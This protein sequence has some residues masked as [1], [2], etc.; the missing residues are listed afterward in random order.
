ME[1]NRLGET[2]RWDVRI[3]TILYYYNNDL[4]FTWLSINS[5]SSVGHHHCPF[6]YY[7]TV[8]CYLLLKLIVLKHSS[9]TQWQL[10]SFLNHQR[11]G[12]HGTYIVTKTRLLVCKYLYSTICWCWQS[13][14]SSLSLMRDAHNRCIT[15]LRWATLDRLTS[16]GACCLLLGKSYISTPSLTGK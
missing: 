16:S 6:Q 2:K 9:I 5:L 15:T 12:T 3:I 7:Y 14:S 8:A 1:I 13:S 4:I 11:N 10:A